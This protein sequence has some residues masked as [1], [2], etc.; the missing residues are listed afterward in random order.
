M[1]DETKDIPATKT[2]TIPED[3]ANALEEDLIRLLDKWSYADYGC[4]CQFCYADDDHGRT[5]INHKH[6]CSGV[7]LLKLLRGD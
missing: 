4:Q 2:I 5:Y 3:L 6:D 1:A 7:K